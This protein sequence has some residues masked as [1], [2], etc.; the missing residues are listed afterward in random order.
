MCNL[1]IKFNSCNFNNNL[2]K[3]LIEFF[4]LTSL[5]FPPVVALAKVVLSFRPINSHLTD[6]HL[7]TVMNSFKVSSG[8]MKK[9][10]ISSD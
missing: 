8:S 1:I 3:L 9:L 2:Y 10:E 7:L 6:K 4:S 5:L